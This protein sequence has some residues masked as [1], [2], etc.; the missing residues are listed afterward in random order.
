[1]RELEHPFL[2]SM[3]AA[4]GA[5]GLFAMTLARPRKSQTEA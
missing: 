2:W 5:Y 3:A 4:F 1:V